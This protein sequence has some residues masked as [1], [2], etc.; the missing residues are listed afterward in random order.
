LT[1]VRGFLL[2]CALT[3]TVSQVSAQ[4]NSGDRPMPADLQNVPR[5][6]GM[7]S[8]LHGVNGGITFA[9][10]HNSAAGWYEVL[11]P[12]LSYSFSAHYSADAS[13]PIYLHRL[14]QPPASGPTSTPKLVLDG[15]DAGDTLIGFHGAFNP[16]C[17]EETATGTL[18]A[19][20][21]NHT[22]GLGTGRVT[23]DLDNR[24]ERNLGPAVLHLD[25]GFGDSAGADSTVLQ[26]NYNTLGFL[27]HFE[28]GAT[29]WVKRYGYLQSVAYEQLP[30]G[31]QKIYQLVKSTT[32][33]TTTTTYQ[34]VS[35]GLSEDNGITTLI[36]APLT[37]HLLFSGYY[38]R[39]LRQ[40]QDTVSLGM[41]FV[42]RG[43]PGRTRL[44][45]IDRALREAAGLT[46]DADTT[47]K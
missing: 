20:T 16:K 33:K 38:S 3:A 41:T 40:H 32:N 26:H 11:E 22:N 12:A 19:P 4:Q 43:M 42:F 8:L 15:S 23:F 36:G 21:G 10:V 45:T 29:F 5:V 17:F 18:T 1:T 44:S 37:G 46:S 2:L 13:A 34:L 7:S 27:A 31:S 30:L 14:V 28:T 9:G 6:P 24:M 35:S 47:K 25:F 39:S